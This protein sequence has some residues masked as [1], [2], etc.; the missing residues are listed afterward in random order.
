MY[1][2]AWA[3]AW[4]ETVA[5]DQAQEK[6]SIGLTRRFK[7]LGQKHLRGDNVLLGLWI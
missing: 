6:S 3:W 4:A 7:T 5:F 2:Q 1:A